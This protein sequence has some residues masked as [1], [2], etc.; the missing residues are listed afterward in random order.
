MTAPC[1]CTNPTGAKGETITLARASAGFCTK[2][3]VT[4]NIANGDLVSCSSNQARV[5]PGGDG[6]SSVGLLI[7]PSRT[8]V[9]LRSEAIDNAA[10]TPTGVGAT[11]PTVTADNATAPNNAATAERVDFAATA[12]GQESSVVQAGVGGAGFTGS[13]SIF[14]KGVSGSGTIDVCT[15]TGAADT[16]T[17]CAFVSATWT[18]CSQL[19]ATVG[20]ATALSIGNLTR[21]NGGTVRSANNV[22]LWG[23]QTEATGLVSSYIATAAASATRASETAS[24]SVSLANTTGSMAASLTPETNL[25]TATSNDHAPLALSV[26]GPIYRILMDWRVIQ[27]A[28]TVYS[29]AGGVAERVYG[30]NLTARADNRMYLYWT[31]TVPTA[32]IGGGETTGAWTNPG[33]ST[34]IEI[35]S[36]SGSSFQANSVVKKVCVDPDPSRC[37]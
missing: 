9:V 11:A 32:G 19:A 14:V 2:A 7:E 22:Y 20:A 8:N 36:G 28:N 24:F 18:R 4:A 13:T 12:A 33:A 25:A 31:G 23:V 1:A 30:L 26:A 29:S 15:N 16:C 21:I 37:R 5:M 27:S 6:A 17:A 3:D 10:W 34:L 35:G